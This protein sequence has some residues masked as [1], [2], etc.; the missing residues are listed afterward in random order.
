MELIIDFVPN[1]VS[2]DYHSL[3]LPEGEKDLGEDDNTSCRFC[4]DNNF[5]YLPDE[6]LR[7]PNHQTNDNQSDA[8]IEYPAKVTGNDVFN[9]YPTADD[10]YETI[11]L[12]Y[13]INYET[14]QEYFSPIPNT[15]R[16][17]TRILLFWASKGVD[18]IREVKKSFENIFFIAEIYEPDR[19]SSYLNEGMFDYLYDKV[20]MYDT[21]RQII[22]SET[23]THALTMLWQ[24][25]EVDNSRMLRF[26]ENHD[27]QRLASEFFA[28]DPWKGL[29]GMA[30]SLLMSTGPGMI[31]FGQELGEEAIGTTGFSGDDGRTSIFDYTTIPSI[32][33][34]ITHEMGGKQSLNDDQLKLRQAYMLLLNLS[35]E[36]IF[37]SGQFYDLMW[38]NEHL[39]DE[40]RSKVYAFIR[41][42]NNQVVMIVC[43]FNCD[44]AEVNIRIPLHAIK[45]LRQDHHTRFTLK[46]IHPGTAKTT[47]LL[48]QLTS[49]GVRIVFDRSGWS[50]LNIHFS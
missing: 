26:L 2:R 14:K 17:M 48:S 37:A 34:W 1:H 13:G 4:T 9:S 46:N 22:T 31:F 6:K 27:E 36:D 40:I 16:K 8:F 15:W 50:A 49:T 21:L 29:P 44:L 32:S 42:L 7:L 25:S 35:A 11:K 43:S 28:G 12:N 33:K 30:I 41:H 19:Y 18:A 39:A 38:A 24:S 3:M 23:S 47:Y 5:Y 10:W 45:H 20:G